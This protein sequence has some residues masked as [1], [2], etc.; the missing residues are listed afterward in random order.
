MTRAG[1]RGAGVGL[2]L[3]SQAW[4]TAGEEVHYGGWKRPNGVVCAGSDGGED[5]VCGGKGDYKPNEEFP[6]KVKNCLGESRR[7]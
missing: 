5:A 6:A 1:F 3:P 7:R 4:V 2:C